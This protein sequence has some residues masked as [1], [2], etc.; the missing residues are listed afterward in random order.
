MPRFARLHSADGFG[1]GFVEM[2]TR[3]T[4]VAS[5]LFFFLAVAIAVAFGLKPITLTPPSVPVPASLFGMHIHYMVT[6][7][8][9]D[10][11]TP[12]PS[13]QVR[14]CRRSSGKTAVMRCSWMAAH[15]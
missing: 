15:I 13:V 3:A 14:K 10:R 7:K 12:W 1:F 8:G 11:L 4:I 9:N 2:K 6:P 5:A